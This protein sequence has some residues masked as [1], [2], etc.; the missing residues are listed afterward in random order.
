[1]VNE[2]LERR[3]TQILDRIP[4]TVTDSLNTSSLADHVVNLY[5]TSNVIHG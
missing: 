4:Q 2:P 5:S 1:M 3:V